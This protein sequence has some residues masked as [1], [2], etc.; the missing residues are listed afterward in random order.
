[1]RGREH[2]QRALCFDCF[3]PKAHCF[4][5]EVRKFDPRI[6]FVILI[7]PKERKRS[8]ATGRMSHLS[9]ENSRLI[10]GVDFSECKEIDRIVA[11][12]GVHAVVMYPG[13]GSANLSGISIAER[14]S[15]FPAGKELVVFVIDGTWAT[16]RKMIRSRNLQTLPRICF[17][18]TA[19]SRFRV[20]R[21]PAPGCYSTV[22]AIHATIELLGPTRGF[23]LEERR[24]D[25]L[26]ALFDKMVERQVTFGGA[27]HD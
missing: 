2:C 14:A 21:Q 11:N 25:G 24:H 1:M 23:A 16:A 5:A 13:K 4:C 18:P 12:P 17:T 6:R 7:H 20:R 10:S 26:L 22:E 8:I 19:P 27:K 3:Q 15:L 9:L